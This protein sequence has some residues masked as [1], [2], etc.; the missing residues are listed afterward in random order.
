MNEKIKINKI[1]SKINN[2]CKCLV[3]I[4]FLLPN[5][6]YRYCEKNFKYDISE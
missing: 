4:M 1:Y 6:K 2:K 3:D 5:Y